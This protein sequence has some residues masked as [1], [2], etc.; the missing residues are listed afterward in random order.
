MF[1][2]CEIT[3]FNAHYLLRVIIKKIMIHVYHTHMFN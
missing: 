1:Y 2:Y 3:H